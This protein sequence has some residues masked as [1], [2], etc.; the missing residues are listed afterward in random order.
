MTASV[1]D[2]VIRFANLPVSR[3]VSSQNLISTLKLFPVDRET[4][5]RLESVGP[6]DRGI[7]VLNFNGLGDQ[8]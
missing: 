5:Q 1:L 6:R 4:F 8:G 3:L 2:A 7:R